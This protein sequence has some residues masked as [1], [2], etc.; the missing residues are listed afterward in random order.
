MSDVSIVGYREPLSCRPGDTVALNCRATT[1]PQ[2]VPLVRTTKPRREELLTKWPRLLGAAV[3]P[4]SGGFTRDYL[5]VTPPA[6]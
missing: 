1:R 4:P 3:P 2:E 5:K 6:T